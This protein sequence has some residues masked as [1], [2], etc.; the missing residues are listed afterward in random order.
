MPAG[1][2]C[3]H[4]ASFLRVNP[5][6][7]NVKHAGHGLWFHDFKNSEF[8]RNEAATTFADAVKIVR[9][10]VKTDIVRDYDLEKIAQACVNLTDPNFDV[11]SFMESVCNQLATIFRPRVLVTVLS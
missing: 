3:Q 1:V 4:V 8:W 10:M 6:R 7:S 11:I 2:H 9:Q 5:F